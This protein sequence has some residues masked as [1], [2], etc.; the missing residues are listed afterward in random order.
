MEYAI[1]KWLHIVSSTILFGTELGSAFFMLMAN[2]S[3]KIS[4][5]DFAVRFVVVADWVFTSPAVLI[6][7]ATG[8]YLV[9]LGGY[10]LTDLWVMSAIGLYVFAGMCWL[11]VVWLQIKMRNMVAA[12]ISTGQALPDRYWAYHWGWVRLGTLA[13]PTV[14]VIFWLMVQKPL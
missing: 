2:R 11:P 9:H 4:W 13:F 3:R 1:V 5:I 12:S 10:S 7:L 14:L 8:L 6:Q